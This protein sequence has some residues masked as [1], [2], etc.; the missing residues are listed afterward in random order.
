MADKKHRAALKRTWIDRARELL[1][2]RTI[3][4]V[5]WLSD[6][7]MQANLWS[8]TCPVLILDDGT[9]LIPVADDEGNQAGVV[10]SR[11]RRATSDSPALWDLPPFAADDP[12]RPRTIADTH[13]FDVPGM[14]TRL[15]RVCNR[16]FTADRLQRFIQTKL[17]SIPDLP[18]EAFAVYSVEEYL[19]TTGCGE[20]VVS[21]LQRYLSRLG[22]SLSH[23]NERDALGGKDLG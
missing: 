11:P 21:V 18:V 23:R 22:I 12:R 4:D 2:G 5:H 15:R 9:Q 14:G 19:D 13:L 20:K 7:E 6:A 16:L 8:T 10:S 17:W 1:V 3:V